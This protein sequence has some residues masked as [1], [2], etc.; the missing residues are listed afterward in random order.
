MRTKL[1]PAL[2]Y[3]LLACRMDAQVIQLPSSQLSLPEGNV[4]G[5]AFDHD[6]LFIQQSIL[7]AD[8]PRVSSERQILSWDVSSNS[9]LKTRTLEDNGPSSLTGDRCGRV[10][11]DTDLHRVFI[12]SSDTALAVL[13]PVTLLTIAL[14]PIKGHIYDFVVDD[15]L[16]RLFVVSQSDSN[17][18]HLYVYN[19]SDGKQVDQIELSSG[20]ADDVRLALDQ[21]AH[22][23]GISESH[24]N[25]SGY[26]TDLYGCHYNDGLNCNQVAKTGQ[27]SEIAV[28]G[29][30]LLA[31]SGL[32]ADDK[33][34]CL[35]QI[36]LM[37]Q[38]MSHPYCA[39]RT[40]VHYGVGVVGRE[41]VVGYTGASKRLHFKEATV[42]LGSS[43]SVWRLENS[44][45]AAETAQHNYDGSFQGG[46]RI[47]SS[48]TQPRFLLFSTTS[49]VAYIYDIKESTGN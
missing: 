10:Q 38:T 26:T 44:K 4:V 36:N 21:R 42:P 49:N 16:H 13:D 1:F 20:Y 2:L 43:V 46:V 14:V 24:L 15:S 19:I 34:V 7:H 39:P 28:V 35:T 8:G 37:N 9:A 23:I 25:H 3:V 6:L 45:I 18:Q 30:E 48:K 47:A 41:Y 40:G 31:A 32:L 11:V 27:V 22:R 33:Q 17:V 5:A 29:A 12:C